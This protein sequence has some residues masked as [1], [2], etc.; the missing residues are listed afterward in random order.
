[1]KMKMKKAKMA[2]IQNQV[3]DPPVVVVHEFH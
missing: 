1:M 2:M 3:P